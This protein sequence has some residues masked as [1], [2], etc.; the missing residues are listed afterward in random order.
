[1]S[2]A[3]EL[4]DMIEKGKSDFNAYY[5]KVKSILDKKTLYGTKKKGVA[6]MK[7]YDDDIASDFEN[8]VT[9]EKSAQKIMKSIANVYATGI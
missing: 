2:K 1:M 3:K 5:K 8:D 7:V 6:D 4:L 9:P